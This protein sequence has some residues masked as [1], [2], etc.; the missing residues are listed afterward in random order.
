MSA[1]TTPTEVQAL[2]DRVAPAYDLLN[3][4]LSLR[5][6]VFWREAAARLARP[7]VEGPIL[8]LACGTLDLSLE[9]ARR[10]PDR[11][12]V[13]VD[14]SLGMLHAGRS[15]LA[16][17]SRIAAVAGD[18][19]RLP[20]A[21]GAF[22]GATIA[23]GIRNIPD[24][25]QAL[26]ELGRVIKPGGRL[27]V[28]EFGVPTGFFRRIYLAYL[29]RILPLLAGLLSPDPA[30]YVYLGRSILEFPTPAEFSALMERAGFIA[31]TMPLNRGVCYL[32]IGDRT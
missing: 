5:R 18:G 31:R 16:A 26:A 13:G 29:T 24:R 1:G 19:T 9:L 4:L 22:A 3:R 32:F 12:I 21:D 30:A 7:A 14:F 28:L 2:F 20:F 27:V 15:K 23:F 25:A 11:R 8:D 10:H 6:D 17:E